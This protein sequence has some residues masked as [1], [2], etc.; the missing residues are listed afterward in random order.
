MRYGSNPEILKYDIK[1]QGEGIIKILPTDPL[2]HKQGTY[3]VTVVADFAFLDL[4]RDNYYTFSI[5][6]R[7]EDSMPH[8]NAQ[9]T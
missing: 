4:F 9:R 1:K 6:W 7:T 5:T 2:Y 8:L 3:Y